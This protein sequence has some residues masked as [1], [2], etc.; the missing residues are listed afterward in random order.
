MFKLRI[1]RKFLLISFLFFVLC[2]GANA[3]SVIGYK[4]PAMPNP[5]ARIELL[6]KQ[7]TMLHNTPPSLGLRDCFLFILDA[8]DT[9]LHDQKDIEWL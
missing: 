4:I 2:L 1:V 5:A 9:K 3:Q 7:W 6:K 8:M